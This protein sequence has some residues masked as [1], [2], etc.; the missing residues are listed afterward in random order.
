MLIIQMQPTFCPDAH[1]IC[2][3]ERTPHSLA[4]FLD[5][6]PRGRLTTPTGKPLKNFYN[7]CFECVDR[8]YLYS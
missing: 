6:I 3:R 7:Q 1:R 2:R 8:G 5:I 4:D